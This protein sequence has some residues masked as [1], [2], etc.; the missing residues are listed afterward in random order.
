MGV[1]H[2]CLEPS[3]KSCDESCVSRGYGEL[4]TVPVILTLG[5]L[6]G[7]SEAVPWGATPSSFIGLYMGP[8]NPS[9]IH[10]PASC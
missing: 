10:V 9:Q 4:G 3:L 6:G 7:G 8:D 2:I 5:Q 1:C